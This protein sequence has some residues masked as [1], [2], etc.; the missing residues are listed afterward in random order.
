MPATEDDPVP[1]VRVPGWSLSFPRQVLSGSGPCPHSAPS[2]CPRAPAFS[3]AVSTR[4]LRS[5]SGNL[6]PTPRPVPEHP[7][8]RLPRRPLPP[9]RFPSICFPGGCKGCVRVLLTPTPVTWGMFLLFIL[10]I[11]C[12]IFFLRLSTCIDVLSWLRYVI[13]VTILLTP[14][15]F[16]AE[17]CI[18]QAV[19]LLSSQ[20]ILLGLRVG[21]C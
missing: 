18:K 15:S 21:S 4:P 10:Q 14:I 16:S 6:A 9:P 2:G 19:N 5:F 13:R 20:V 17:D 1:H 3:P 11:I 12:H 8:V 7:R